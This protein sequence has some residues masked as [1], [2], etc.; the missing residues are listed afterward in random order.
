MRDIK[1]RATVRK[2]GG[3]GLLTLFF[4]EKRLDGASSTIGALGG[5]SVFY[6]LRLN[7]DIG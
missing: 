3:D 5:T 6:G 4:S 7:K 1:E 2:V